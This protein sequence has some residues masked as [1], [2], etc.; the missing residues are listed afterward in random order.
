MG[1][2]CAKFM[3]L[4]LPKN[5]G[6]LLLALWLI[7]MGVLHLLNITFAARDTLLEILAIAAGVFLLLEHR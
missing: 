7:L 2:S 1:V 3:N 4:K 5:F 6:I